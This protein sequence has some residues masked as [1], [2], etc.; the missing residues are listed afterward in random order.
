MREN[1]GVYITLL[2]PGELKLVGVLIDAAD[3]D[4]EDVGPGHRKRRLNHIL[5]TKTGF[6]F[7]F[8]TDSF[9]EA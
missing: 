8:E 9:L 6:R 7:L 2:R 1:A 3:G 4:L 5:G